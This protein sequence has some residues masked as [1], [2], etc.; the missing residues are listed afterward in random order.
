[1]GVVRTLDQESRET[2]HRA[3]YGAQRA[4]DAP[5]LVL[6]YGKHRAAVL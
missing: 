2:F 3:A 5:L 1:M 6:D 4:R